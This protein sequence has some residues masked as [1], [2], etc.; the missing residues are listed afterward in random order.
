MAAASQALR[1]LCLRSCGR[2]P[3]LQ[4]TVPIRRP[5]YRR[6]LSSSGPRWADDATP[7][8]DGKRKKKR[9]GR[10]YETY[11]DAIRAMS[12]EELKQLEEIV[13]DPNQ[14]KSLTTFLDEE[15]QEMTYAN[16][17]LAD[18]TEK[19]ITHPRPNKQSFWYDEDDSDIISE[20]Y[21]DEMKEDDMTP[22]AHGKLDEI[23]DMRQWTRVMAWEMPLLSSELPTPSIIFKGEDGVL[24]AR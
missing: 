15:R 23:R 9:K 7:A 20:D 10:P 8:D 21:E 16:R 6:A 12:P 13:A 11:D 1:L 19:R 5:L 17:E 18:D 4:T 2:I 24:T 3:T 22:M 14:S